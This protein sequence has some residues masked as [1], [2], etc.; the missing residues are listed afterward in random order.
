M[1]EENK[2]GRITKYK[3]PNANAKSGLR[4]KNI[5]KLDLSREWIIIKN[6]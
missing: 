5:F 6:Y 3:E 4:I 2:A 1:V